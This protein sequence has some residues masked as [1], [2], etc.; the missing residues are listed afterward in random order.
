MCGRI[1]RKSCG[2]FCLNPTAAWRPAES[3]AGAPAPS[4]GHQTYTSSWIQFF[5]VLA[6]IGSRQEAIGIKINTTNKEEIDIKARWLVRVRD[7]PS[8]QA[9]D[10]QAAAAG[11]RPW[12]PRL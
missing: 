7:R 4:S 1:E 12:R 3:W 11:S 5:W 8:K 9:I 10:L 2:Y 6:Y